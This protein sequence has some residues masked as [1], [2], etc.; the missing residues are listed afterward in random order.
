MFGSP[1]NINDKEFIVM[2]DNLSHTSWKCK[3]HIVF[4]PFILSKNGIRVIRRILLKVSLQLFLD[5]A[6]K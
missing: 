5:A 2:N 3:Y 1:T 6:S 4:A